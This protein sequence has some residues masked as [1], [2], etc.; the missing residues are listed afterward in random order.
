MDL[1]VGPLVIL[2]EDLGLVLAYQI[3]AHNYLKL[4]VVGI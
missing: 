4:Q 2:A 3:A 1:W